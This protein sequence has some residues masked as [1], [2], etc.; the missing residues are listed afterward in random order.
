MSNDY[1]VPVGPYRSIG[2]LARAL[3]YQ[4]KTLYQRRFR[5]LPLVTG[6]EVF[7]LYV[8]HGVQPCQVRPDLISFKLRRA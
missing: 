4:P 1:M 8:E 3:G 7:R 6:E 5:N 2:E